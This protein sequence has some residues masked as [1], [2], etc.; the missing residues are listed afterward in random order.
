MIL[1]PPTS[2]RTC[3]LFP[4]RT[5][6]RSSNR[7]PEARV[8]PKY[9][10]SG[11]W[12]DAARERIFNSNA[13]SNAPANARSLEVPPQ[14]HGEAIVLGTYHYIAFGLFGAFCAFDLIA[15]SRDFPDI[16]FWRLK[17]VAFTML[18]FAVAPF[19]QIGRASCRERVCL[20]V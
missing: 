5:L 14:S 13:G 18:Y 10:N 8:R 7:R 9:Q 15:R 2:K 19:A 16:R 1:R 20:Y 11:R 17:G 12:K 4:Y 3:T 6:F